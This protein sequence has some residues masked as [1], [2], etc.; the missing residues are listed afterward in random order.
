M[1]EKKVEFES[2]KRLDKFGT[3]QASELRKAVAAIGV[4]HETATAYTTE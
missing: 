2:R 1:M 3:K 4:I